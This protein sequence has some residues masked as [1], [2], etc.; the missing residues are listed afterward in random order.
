LYKLLRFSL[1]RC[2][3]NL[4]TDQFCNELVEKMRR[5]ESVQAEAK[6]KQE[7]SK[8]ILKTDDD[9]DVNIFIT[10]I[11]D[12]DGILEFNLNRKLKHLGWSI[13]RIERTRRN[14]LS[15]GMGLI[16]WDNRGTRRF[17]YHS[18]TV[19]TTIQETL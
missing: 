16:T 18:P 10:I 5:Q 3:S 1:G 8:P 17:Y 13:R 6:L 12:N 4:I 9:K 7:A 15:F 11:Q 14:A 2:L 19:T